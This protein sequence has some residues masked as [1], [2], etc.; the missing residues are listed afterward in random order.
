MPWSYREVLFHSLP[1]YSSGGFLFMKNRFNLEL[2][3]PLIMKGEKIEF[4]EVEI[5]AENDILFELSPFPGLHEFSLKDLN[6]DH[7][8][9]SFSKQLADFTKN[10]VSNSGIRFNSLYVD[11]D[12]VSNSNVLKIKCGRSDIDGELKFVLELIQK[13]KNVKLRLDANQSWD[14][15]QLHYFYNSLPKDNI[16]YFEEPVK[17]SHKL[18]DEIPIALDESIYLNNEMDFQHDVFVIKP[19][20][21]NDFNNFLKFLEKNKQKRLIFSSLFESSVGMRELLR[22][23][24]Y[25]NLNDYHGFDPFNF[26][27]SDVALNPIIYQDGILLDH[28]QKFELLD[29]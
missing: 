8:Y 2:K 6:E 7:W 17:D 15:D 4:R 16:D 25:F 5:I 12:S 24:T 29:V 27:T 22:L 19:K 28:N 1:K 10:I 9:F 18:S 20:L 3:N 26:L 14:E 11:G 21:F 23:A 13:Y